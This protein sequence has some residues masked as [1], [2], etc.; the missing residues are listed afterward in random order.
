MEIEP[1][2]VASS[3]MAVIAQ[4]LLRF[5]CGS[6][7]ESYK[8][9]D[10]ELKKVGIKREQLKDGMLY[11]AKGCDRCFDMGYS[12]RTAIFEMLLVDDD[13]RNLTLSNVDSGQIKR[14][15]IEHG[16][17]PLR[18][19]GADHIIRGVTSVDEVMRVTEEENNSS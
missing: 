15:A 17:T 1:F 16:M 14:K 4:R 2:L 3:L 7:K 11:R 12:G 5:L 10:D 18:M 6:C 13:I 19:D 8:P 9:S